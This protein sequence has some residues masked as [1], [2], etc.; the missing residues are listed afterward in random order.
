MKKLVVR[1]AK[2][3]EAEVLTHLAMTAKASWGSPDAGK[4]VVLS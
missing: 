1:S 4:R 3:S 2:P